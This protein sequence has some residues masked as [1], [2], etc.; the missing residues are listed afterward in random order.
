MRALWQNLGDLDMLLIRQ[1]LLRCHLLHLYNQQIMGWMKEWRNAHIQRT[2]IKG[3]V[4]A[5]KRDW[6]LC[7]R[8]PPL[9]RHWLALC[10]CG[11][12]TETASVFRAARPTIQY[13]EVNEWMKDEGKSSLFLTFTTAVWSHAQMNNG[14]H[15]TWALCKLFFSLFIS[16]IL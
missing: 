14:N 3:L 8:W 5:V 7:F 9:K 2:D 4:E 1:S 12:R 6:L 10:L 16:S 15:L 11:Q 13:T